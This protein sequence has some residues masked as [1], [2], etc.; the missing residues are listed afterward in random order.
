MVHKLWAVIIWIVQLNEYSSTLCDELIVP[1]NFFWTG[2]YLIHYIHAW[3]FA[4]PVNS[5]TLQLVAADLQLQRAVDTEQEM[6]LCL[7]WLCL[8]TSY[9]AWYAIFIKTITCSAFLM[10]T[11]MIWTYLI[12]YSV[13]ILK[14]YWQY[15]IQL[16]IFIFKFVDWS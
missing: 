12:F 16:Y 7:G 13:T 8:K 9:T 1:A 10:A 2:Y 15:I 3:L 11:S 4:N 14:I 6:C 5:P